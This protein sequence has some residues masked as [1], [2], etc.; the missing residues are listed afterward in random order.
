MYLAK[1]YFLFLLNEQMN[2]MIAGGLV[3]DPLKTEVVILIYKWI[4]MTSNK[5]E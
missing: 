4:K 5:K 2:E 1:I 3:G